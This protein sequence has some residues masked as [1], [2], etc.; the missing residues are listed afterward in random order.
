MNRYAEPARASQ[1]D[2]G[3][4]CS[5]LLA[6]AGVVRVVAACADPSVFAGGRGAQ[7]LR[8]SGVS[9][10][11]GLL[12]SEAAELYGAYRPANSLESRR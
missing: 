4:S 10:D 8:Q 12:N 3:V 9:L 1:P 11:H 7:I 6:G 2:G 5:A